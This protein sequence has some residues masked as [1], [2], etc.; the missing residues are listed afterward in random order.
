[1]LSVKDGYL[2]MV[3]IQFVGVLPIV[4]S[5]KFIWLSDSGSAVNF[6]F[7][8]SILKSSCMFLKSVWQE[9]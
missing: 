6:M 9:S 8:W 5:K 7:G 3:V 4:M 1:M 2:Y